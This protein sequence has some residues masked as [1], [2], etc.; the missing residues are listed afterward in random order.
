M[1]SWP[2]P[3]NLLKT[4]FATF[5]LFSG[6][7]LVDGMYRVVD[8][9]S[10]VTEFSRVV[11]RGP[12]RPHVYIPEVV[13]MGSVLIRSSEATAQDWQKPEILQLRRARYQCGYLDG[14]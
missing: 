14:E 13:S 6:F 1:H 11:G 12:G 7:G 10:N 4:C 5:E 3:L 2:I 8:L 9:P